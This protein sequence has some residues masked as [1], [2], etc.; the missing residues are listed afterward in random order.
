MFDGLVREVELDDVG[1]DAFGP[2]A[3][4]PVEV[5][6]ELPVGRHVELFDAGGPVPAPFGPELLADKRRVARFGD[7]VGTDDVGAALD[8][9]RGGRKRDG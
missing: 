3:A 4:D 1:D 2:V 5:A 9:H 6:D 7:V 8:G